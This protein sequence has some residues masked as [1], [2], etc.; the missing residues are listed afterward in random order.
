MF[1]LKVASDWR[2]EFARENTQLITCDHQNINK[3]LE[4]SDPVTTR[5]PIMESSNLSIDKFLKAV[6]QTTQALAENQKSLAQIREALE[7]LNDTV[8]KLCVDIGKIR[9]T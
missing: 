4:E 1:C 5:L 8:R 6:N 7:M 2:T 3:L 9:K